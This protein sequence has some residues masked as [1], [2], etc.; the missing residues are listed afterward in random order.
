[1]IF[2]YMIIFLNSKCR[3]LS[4]YCTCYMILL[5]ILHAELLGRQRK[6]GMDKTEQILPSM[7]QKS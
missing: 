6:R 4:V 3:L 1:M 5:Y 7:L 2:K